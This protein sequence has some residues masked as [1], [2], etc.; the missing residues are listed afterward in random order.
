MYTLYTFHFLIMI[1]QFRLGKG[2]GTGEI[3]VEGKEKEGERKEGGQ[4]K[5]FRH[6][7]QQSAP[8]H[9][10]EVLHFRGKYHFPIFVMKK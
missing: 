8:F 1:F 4:D 3:E 9:V 6:K 10:V 2:G 5:H 7:S